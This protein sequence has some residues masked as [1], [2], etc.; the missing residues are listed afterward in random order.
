MRDRETINVWLCDTPRGHRQRRSS[1]QLQLTAGSAQLTDHHR[2]HTADQ[3]TC[4]SAR[5]RYNKDAAAQRVPY[6][7]VEGSGPSRTAYARV[8]MLFCSLRVLPN[9]RA[10]RAA[11]ETSCTKMLDRV[12]LL[13]GLYGYL[14]GHADY[15][16]VDDETVIA[17]GSIQT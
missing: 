13:D 7:S 5:E 3:L 16:V 15:I 6:K 8:R 14:H 17:G 9:A 1:E 11:S 2:L 12:S 10:A 4:G